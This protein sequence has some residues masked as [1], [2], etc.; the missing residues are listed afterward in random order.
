MS[1]RHKPKSNKNKSPAT[2]NQESG[3]ENMPQNIHVRGE[4]EISRS[5]SLTQVHNTERQEDAT[6]DKKRYLVEVITLCFVIIVAGLTGWQGCL[7]RRYV[8]ISQ[9][10]Y[11]TTRTQFQLD[12]RPYVMPIAYELKD[13]PTG[14]AIPPVKGHPFVVN[15]RIK[16]IGKSPALNVIIHRHLVWGDDIQKF[17]PE[18][19]DID[20]RTGDAIG[21]G[22]TTVT[23]AASLKDT[24]ANE[25]ADIEKDQLAVWDGKH[26]I[27]VFGRI[28]YQDSFDK[29]YC[30][31]FADR[32]FGPSL[33]ERI[34]RVF[35]ENIGFD[36]RITDMCP[37][38]TGQMF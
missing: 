23:S 12:Q 31:P 6:Q 22:E 19:P 26:P 29:V 8:G 18:P 38:G 21:Q 24:F 33:W 20:K 9:Q 37:P 15:I 35:K 30:T 5:P 16:N 3:E 11:D 10:A 25:T 7:T 32:Y 1:H 14:K 36:R 27:V 28:T 34:G 4:I 2:P 13:F 17:R